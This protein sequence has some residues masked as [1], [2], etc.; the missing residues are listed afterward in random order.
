[1]QRWAPMPPVMVNAVA[2]AYV[3]RDGHHRV[4][5]ARLA[6]YSHVPALLVSE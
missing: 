5:A 6:G 4:E 1:M 2:G 3:L